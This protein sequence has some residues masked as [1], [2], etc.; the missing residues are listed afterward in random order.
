MGSSIALPHL[1]FSNL[2]HVDESQGHADFK[3]L[4]LV[5]EHSQ[6]LCDY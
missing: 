3:A 5:K 6:A 2:D 1:T 4:Y